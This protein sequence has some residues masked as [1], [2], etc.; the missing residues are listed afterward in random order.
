MYPQIYIIC[1]SF[2]NKNNGI[3]PIEYIKKHK[4][5]NKYN[6]QNINSSLYKK[7]TLFFL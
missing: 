3:N 6:T 5:N 4:L 2:L 7:M 1:D